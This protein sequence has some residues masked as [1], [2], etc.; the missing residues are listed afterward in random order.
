MNK[1]MKKLIAIATLISTIS[2]AG[3]PIYSAANNLTFSNS[4]ETKSF[5][6]NGFL[7]SHLGKTYALTAKHVLFEAQKSGI[8]SIDIADYLKSWTLKPFNSDS[9]EVVLGSLVNKDSSEKLD[10]AVLQN[11]WLLFEVKEN[12]STLQVL[13]LSS[14]TLKNNESIIAFG[15]SYSNQKKCTQN[16]YSGHYVKSENNNLLIDLD[17]PADKMNTLRG[18]SGAPVVNGKN[19]VVG[20]VSNIIP[21]KESDKVYFAP[22]SIEPVVKYLNDLKI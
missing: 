10:M 9:G 3:Q 12:N 15:C 14:E 19:E 2:F 1:I 20:I 18:L 7:I 13:K 11:D 22:F 4:N 5:V 8:Q 6:G 16:K 21:D 17:M